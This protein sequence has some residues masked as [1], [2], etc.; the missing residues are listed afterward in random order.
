MSETITR[1]QREIQRV[2]EMT[3]NN[4]R[5]LMTETHQEQQS[6]TSLLSVQEREELIKMISQVLPA[7][8]V[9]SFILGGILNLKGREVSPSEG[10]THIGSLLK[11][12]SI[13]RNNAFYSMMFVG[14]ATVLAGYNMLLKLAGVDEDRFLPDGVWQFYTEF[15]LREDTGRHQ[16]ETLGFQQAVKSL[17][18]N[19]VE[20]LSAWM[21]A[22]M[23]LLRVYDDLLANEWEE[24]T[25]IKVIQETTGLSG[26]HRIWQ[27]IIP[28]TLPQGEQNLVL[29]RRARFER[30]CEDQLSS[31]GREQRA[32]FESLWKSRAEAAKRKAAMQAYQGQMDIRAY[33]DASEYNERRVTIS[34]KNLHIGVIYKQ[35]YYVIKYTDPGSPTA[36][37]LMQQHAQAVLHGTGVAAEIDLMLAKIPRGEQAEVRRRLH[38]EQEHAI[39]RL[40]T[41]PILINWD[42]VSNNQPLSAIRERHRGI[43][44]HALTL[45]RTD[46]STVFDFSH[47]FFDGPWAMAVAEMMTGE[48]IR[49]AQIRG[50]KTLP[51]PK[52][53]NALNLITTAEF[54]QQAKKHI[55]RIANVS[56]E[57]SLSIAP[58]TELRKLLLSRTDGV[59]L[60]IN[61]LLVMYRSIFNQVYQPSPQVKRTVES[62]LRGKDTHDLAQA[63]LDDWQARQ[64]INPSMMI[65]IDASQSNPRDRIFPSIFRSPFTDLLQQHVRACETLHAVNTYYFGKKQAQEDF[66]AARSEYLSTLK[67]F[68]E[69]MRR[70]R[71]I[72][73]QGQSTSAT[74]IRL[75]AGLPGAMQKVADGIPGRL[76]FMN[77]ALKG[78]EVFSN[79]GQVAPGSSLSRF[80]SAKDDN[81]KKVLVWGVLTDNNSVMH[82]TLRDFRPAVTALALGGFAELAQQI[83]QDFVG[84]YVKGLA[85]FV[86]EIK[87]IVSAPKF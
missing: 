73:I 75:I 13:V 45:F 9:T 23:W 19:E 42:E 7:G 68:G 77:E 76:S 70:Y 14:P 54:A 3:A 56:A 51:A 5:R 65:P 67:A 87:T 27:K 37:A 49:F 35:R 72:A 78:E 17:R 16:S 81:D 39:A 84:S 8:N 61:D 80:V 53:A 15:G 43:G 34:P 71:D 1:D 44:D 28:Y 82:I 18:L 32:N 10:R 26:L 62:L 60:T 85:K 4:I 12:L 64:E 11:G 21:M 29:Y 2:N 36:L 63:M 22:S 57:A 58:L 30:F 86:D 79:V 6:N 41:A 47:L 55:P 38:A 40:Q 50:A 31:V 48:A 59:S 46:N 33:L 24:R 69:V 66:R 25:R 83:T 20:M 74:A 52:P